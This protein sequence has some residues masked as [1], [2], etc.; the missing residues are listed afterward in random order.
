MKTTAPELFESGYYC[1][2]SIVK[3]FS[4][5]LGW[6]SDLCTSAASGFCS[7]IG[8]TMGS[9]GAFSG[10]IMVLGLLNGRFKP[11]DPMEE[12]Y[13]KVQVFS[14]AFQNAFGSTNCYQLIQCD[15]KTP[16]GQKDFVL[17]EKMD[18]ICM[19][20]VKQTQTILENLIEQPAI[21]A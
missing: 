13:R 17:N 16:E 14:K 19:S 8:R 7:G 9:C 4:E 6:D 15:L 20:V 12:L 11:D 3:A 10:G 18:T 2:E 5:T 21:P 1:A